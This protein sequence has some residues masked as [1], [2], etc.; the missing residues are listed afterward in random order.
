MTDRTF[1]DTNVLVYRYDNRDPIKQLRAQELLKTGLMWF[2]KLITS[3]F[4]SLNARP[5]SRCWPSGATMR[6]D[7][8]RG[9]PSP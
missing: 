7:T 4:T 2:S 8:D 5:R 6:R 3:G 9:S 1:I